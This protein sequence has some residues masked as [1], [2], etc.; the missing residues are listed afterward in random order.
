[1]KP[2]LFNTEMVKA[3]LDGR[4]IVTRRIIKAIPTDAEFQGWLLDSTMQEDAKDIGKA[5][6]KTNDGSEKMGCIFA[7]PKYEI[8]D[9]LYVR[10]SWCHGSEAVECLFNENI[11]CSDVFYKASW[12]KENYVRWHPSIHMPKEAAR[13]FLK[14]TGVRVERLQDITEEQAVKEGCI[15]FSQKPGVFDLSAKHAFIDLWNGTLKKDS[16]CTWMHNPWLWVIEFERISKEV[17]Y[18]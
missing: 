9:I 5:A 7:K 2:I 6:F 15:S 18:A 17:D 13:I 16:D 12:D 11:K 4:K 3:I 8:G 10:E 14:V 1:M